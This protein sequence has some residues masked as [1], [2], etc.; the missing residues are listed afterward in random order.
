VSG[1]EKCVEI[2]RIALI[3][4]SIRVMVL[5]GMWLPEEEAV[6]GNLLYDISQI[7]IPF[8]N[9]DKEFLE[10]PQRWDP[11][12]IGRFMIYFGPISSIFDV[13]TFALLWYVFDANTVGHQTL[14]QTGWF[15]ECLLSQTLIV[16]MIRTR[17]IPFFQS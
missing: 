7:A 3:P 15:V 12:E 17:K 16:H 2:V 8:D 4:D 13:T 9:V 5:V 1:D 6:W 10:K 14:F 11:K